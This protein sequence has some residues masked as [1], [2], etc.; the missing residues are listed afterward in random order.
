MSQKNYNFNVDRRITAAAGD[1]LGDIP[2]MIR[3]GELTEAQIKTKLDALTPF[4][5]KAAKQ[6]NDTLAKFK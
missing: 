3:K 5:N 4:F 6:A 2:A 1:Q